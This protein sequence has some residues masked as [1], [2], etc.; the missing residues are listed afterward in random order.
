[1]VSVLVCDGQEAHGDVRADESRAMFR[2][3]TELGPFYLLRTA[4]SA[5]Q[6]VN[7]LLYKLEAAPTGDR[8]RPHVDLRFTTL[9]WNPNLSA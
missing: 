1:M 2:I 6:L 7:I 3:G 8:V 5:P 9:S 4:K